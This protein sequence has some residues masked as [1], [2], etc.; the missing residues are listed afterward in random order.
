MDDSTA[1]MILYLVA[2]PLSVLALYFVLRWAISRFPSQTR[3][4]L[5]EVKRRLATIEE[6][7]THMAKREQD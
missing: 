4:D 6:I 3:R 2:T 7:V 5:E 1:Y